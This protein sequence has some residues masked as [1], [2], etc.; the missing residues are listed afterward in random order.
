VVIHL[1]QYIHYLDS[2]SLD[3][4]LEG[5]GVDAHVYIREAF[6][7]TPP[8]QSPDTGIDTASMFQ[9]LCIGTISA[10][11]LECSSTRTELGQNAAAAV[12]L[13]MCIGGYV[14]SKRALAMSGPN[15]GLNHSSELVCFIARWGVE[16]GREDVD[17]ILSRYPEVRFLI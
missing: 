15:S 17:A 6:A 16:S 4:G 2:L 14:D 5:V 3:L 9:G 13:A 11:V 12:R 7:A 10:A 1:A 8:A